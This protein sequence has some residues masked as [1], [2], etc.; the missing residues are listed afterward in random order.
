M[1]RIE[2]YLKEKLARKGA[3][4]IAITTETKD[5]LQIKFSNS[6]ISIVQSWQ[7]KRISIFAA[8][9]KKTISTTMKEF[10]ERAADEIIAGIIKFSEAL[11]PNNE[12]YG[13]AKGPF[14][15]RETKDLYDSKIAELNEKL[16]DHVES[17]IN[18]A[19]KNGAIRSAGVLQAAEENIS[20]LTSNG[21]DAEDRGTS[22]YYSI[23]AF[24]DREATG[25]SVN[26]ARI[27][28]QLKVN[29]A[30]S[31]A[32]I[33]ARNGMNPEKGKPGKYD[34]LFEPL[35]IANLLESAGN[36]ASIF[37]I[38][39]GLSC[40]S[41]R[42]GK[43]IAAEM[44][45]LADDPTLKHGINSRKFDAEGVPAQKN[46]IIEKGILKTYLHNTSSAARHGT[47]TTANAGIISPMPFNLVLEKGNLNKEDMIHQI[48][49][50]ILVTNVWYTRF[51]NYST[52]DFS[53]IPRDG[54]FLIENG[55][56]KKAIK[57]I[58]ISDNLINV[59]MH[60][61]G[62][63]NVPI[64]VRGWENEIPVTTPAFLT[65]EVNITRSAE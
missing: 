49:K 37:N 34:I 52:G 31:I 4:D 60:A 2:E 20:L 46:T 18:A 36:A 21:I 5:S 13:I 40:F 47:K 50:G 65:G 56:I 39:A 28:P 7:E 12:F 3:S 63:G 48:K 26:N 17:G 11:N 9:G 57:D 42:L 44:V 43:K 51:Q 1:K 19:E 62:I 33:T 55:Q 6:R 64:A 14:T 59:L 30:A 22:L 25:H 16:I 23:R 53:T 35:P 58:R 61:K 41:D 32:A 38:E 54:I 27:L 8:I 45:T 24:A 10:S 29:E 15:Y